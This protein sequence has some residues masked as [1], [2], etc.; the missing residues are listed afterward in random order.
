MHVYPPYK[1]FIGPNLFL[2]FCIDGGWVNGG[3]KD[4]DKTLPG[5]GILSQSLGPGVP[6]VRS[7]L[8]AK[9]W[10]TRSGHQERDVHLTDA[11]S[12][13]CVTATCVNVTVQ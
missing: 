3:D 4:A 13:V 7:G 9:T 11:V 6:H 8:H 10:T 5:E 12:S 1:L 2:H